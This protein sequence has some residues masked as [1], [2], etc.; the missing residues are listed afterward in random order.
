MGLYY[1]LFFF[2]FT[3]LLIKF[4][5]AN[6]KRIKRIKRIKRKKIAFIFIVITITAALNADAV[7]NELVFEKTTASVFLSL[8]SVALPIIGFWIYNRRRY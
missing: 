6:G 2:V 4:L 3:A 5:L 8:L 7:H 1:S